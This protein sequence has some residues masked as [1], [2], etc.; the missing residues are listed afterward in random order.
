[1]H[2]HLHRFNFNDV[3]EG[4]LDVALAVTQEKILCGVADQ[5]RAREDLQ[6]SGW[7]EGTP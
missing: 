2:D 3:D 4:N 7:L 6:A 1:V 5:T